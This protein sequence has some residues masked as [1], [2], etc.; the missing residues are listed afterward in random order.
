MRIKLIM[1]S[2][3]PPNTDP[4]LFTITAAIVGALSAGDFNSYEL[5]KAYR[6]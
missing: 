5:Y 1:N 4:N 2:N 3:F 6:N